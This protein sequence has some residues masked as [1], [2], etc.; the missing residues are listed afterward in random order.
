MGGNSEENN[1]QNNIQ[2]VNQEIYI[3]TEL[4]KGQNYGFSFTRQ[5]AGGLGAIAYMAMVAYHYAKSNKLNFFLIEEGKHIPRF[6]GVIKDLISSQKSLSS[7]DFPPGVLLPGEDINNE[8]SWHDYF[9]SLT[10]TPEKNIGTSWQSCPN[11][12]YN[13]K[14]D[15]YSGTRMEWYSNLMK[16]V[17][18]LKDNIQSIIH[19]EVIKSGFQ[20]TDIVIHIRRTDKIFSYDHSKIEQTEL[21]IKTYFDETMEEIRKCKIANIITNEVITYDINHKISQNPRVFLCTDDKAI[22]EELEKMFKEVNIEMVWDKRETNLHMQPLRLSGKLSTTQSREDTIVAM[23]NIEIF[24]RCIYLIGA[25]ASYFFRVGEL[26]RY[27]K[28]SKNI[29][30]S[31]AF[32]KANYAEDDEQIV[33]VNNVW[34][35]GIELWNNKSYKKCINDEIRTLIEVQNLP[36]L[37]KDER[38]I[39]INNVFNQTTVNEINSDIRNFNANWWLY[40]IKPGYKQ[41]ISDLTMKDANLFRTMKHIRRKE[42]EGYFCYRFKRTIDKPGFNHWPACV[43]F[44]CRFRQTMLSKGMMDFLSAVTGEEVIHID[45]T[46]A[47]LYSQGDF[48]NT[49]HD[50]DKGDYTFIIGLTDNWKEEYGGSTNFVDSSNKNAI[51]KK[52]LPGMNT[53]VIFKLKKDDVEGLDTPFGRTGRMDHYVE[54]VTAP[55]N[56]IAYTGWFNVKK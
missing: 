10:F 1:D 48:L 12:F 54:R 56:R 5:N 46:F 23:K 2:N 28:P 53:M 6:D 3:P 18:D 13:K 41:D 42:K 17:Y 31:D 50:K 25:R 15:F 32:G 30:D 8:R 34:G 9:K 11:G 55:A 51:Y 4:N 7:S 39:I 47:S 27:P 21:N 33:R 20:D 26:L 44:S 35:S 49:H 36:K 24:R 45:E 19:Y 29:K 22:C 52:I 38:I 37:L 14:P 16:E 43:C 40:S